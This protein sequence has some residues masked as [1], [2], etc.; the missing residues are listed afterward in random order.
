MPNLIKNLV[1]HP[2]SKRLGTLHT[3]F[4]ANRTSGF[5]TI[6]S[7]EHT[8]LENDEKEKNAGIQ[9]HCGV[10]P[11]FADTMHGADYTPL[12][13]TQNSLA[14]YAW[15]LSSS[16][17]S[18]SLFCM[19]ARRFSPPLFLVFYALSVVTQALDYP[20]CTKTLWKCTGMEPILLG[21]VFESMASMVEVCCYSSI[22]PN[23]LK[24]TS[25]RGQTMEGHYVHILLYML[26]DWH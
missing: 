19:A 18:S 9:K 25:R 16:F 12:K 14:L 1:W 21:N 17:T 3:E 23:E 5:P 8:L 2:R 20:G 10:L 22:V 24:Q 11:V 13:H 4:E 26:P 15:P 7:L 6:W